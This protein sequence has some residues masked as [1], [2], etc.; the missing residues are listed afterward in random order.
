MAA[1]VLTYKLV[2]LSYGDLK[3][4]KRKKFK[5]DGSL[6]I[7]KYVLWR[8]GFLKIGNISARTNGE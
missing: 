8:T 2:S 3:F 5:E 7:F 4:E 1:R 6:T